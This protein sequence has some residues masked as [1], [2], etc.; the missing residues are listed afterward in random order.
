MIGAGM[1]QPKMIEGPEAYARF[2]N[3]MKA[4]VA[5]PHVEIKRR[6]EKQE[7]ESRKNPNRRGPKPKFKPSASPA[8]DA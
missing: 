7:E 1:K 3:T 8:P 5:V 2:A 6:I 4:V